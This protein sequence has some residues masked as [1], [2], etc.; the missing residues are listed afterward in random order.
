MKLD[1]TEQGEVRLREVF[2]GVLHNHHEAVLTLPPKELEWPLWVVRTGNAG[3][4]FKRTGNEHSRLYELRYCMV[5]FVLCTPSD[6]A[7]SKAQISWND[8]QNY[9]T[10]MY[11]YIVGRHSKDYS[12]GFFTKSTMDPDTVE[13][14]NFTYRDLLLDI[15]SQYPGSTFIDDPMNQREWKTAVEQDIENRRRQ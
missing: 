12:N 9:R 1:V 3:M 4:V 11:P 10:S 2:S 8:H 7:R 15:E 13:S 6:D 5:G 14:G